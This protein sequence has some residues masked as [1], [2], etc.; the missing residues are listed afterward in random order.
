VS[1]VADLPALLTAERLALAD[2]LD[3]LA[4]EQ[5]EVQTLCPA[6]TVHQ[7]AAHLVAPIEGSTGLLLR[8]VARARGNADRLGLLVTEAFADLPST[9]LVRRLRAGAGQVAAPPF[10]GIL[11]PVTDALVH[12][13]DIRIPLGLSDPGPAER[14]RPSLDFLLSRRAR[15]GFLP[16]A[17]PRLTYAATDTDWTGGAGPRVEAPAGALAL[18]L[19]RRTPRLDELAGPGAEALRSWATGNN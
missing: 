14:W 5:W 13:E 16:G 4:P 2:L 15:F 17:A 8:S 3:S 7:M 10:V 1:D 6:W 12:G 18:A 9:E 11:G 19:L